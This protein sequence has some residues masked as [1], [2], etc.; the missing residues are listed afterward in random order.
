MPSLNIRDVTPETMKEIRV[1]AAHSGESIRDWVLTAIKGKLGK[2]ITLGGQI[3][4]SRETERVVGAP[5]VSGVWGGVSKRRMGDGATKV[6]RSSNDTPA[7]RGTVGKGGGADPSE[8]QV[9]PWA[10]PKHAADCKC[11]KCEAERVTWP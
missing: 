4:G 2:P 11:T 3:N 5:K 10:G 8:Q 1:A 7:D 9:K 6:L